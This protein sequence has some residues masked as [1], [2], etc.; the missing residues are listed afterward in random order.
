MTELERELKQALAEQEELF[1]SSLEAATSSY[2]ESVKKI[3]ESGEQDLRRLE[4]L[5][6][7]IAAQNQLILSELQKDLGGANIIDQLS[8]LFEKFSTNLVTQ[9]RLILEERLPRQ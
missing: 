5:C 2:E 8:P 1:K 7:S 6:S 4:E 9:L 3:V